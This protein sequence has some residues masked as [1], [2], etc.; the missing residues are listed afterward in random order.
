MRTVDP[1]TLPRQPRFT[2]DYNTDIGLLRQTLSP[3]TWRAMRLPDPGAPRMM[4]WRELAQMYGA[5]VEA[6]LLWN[7]LAKR[8]EGKWTS[9]LDD[10]DTVL[11]DFY[12]TETIA[13][14][15]FMFLHHPGFRAGIRLVGEGV[16]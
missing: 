11:V 15:R 1:A 8:V 5:N 13:V 12:D 3:D 2:N 14:A 16:A 9:R 10:L 7:G 4:R 6:V